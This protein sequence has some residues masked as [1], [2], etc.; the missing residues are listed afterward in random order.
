M[1]KQLNAPAEMCAVAVIARPVPGQ[2]FPH[3]ALP[4]GCFPTA[5]DVDGDNRDSNAYPGR[6]GKAVV[7]VFPLPERPP[8]FSVSERTVSRSVARRNV[9]RTA[10]L[11]ARPAQFVPR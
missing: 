4:R 6:N 3:R 8:E 11:P 1:R 7:H 9:L 10:A 2:S 5:V